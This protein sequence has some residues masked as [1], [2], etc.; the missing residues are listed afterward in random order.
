MNLCQEYHYSI[1]QVSKFYKSWSGYKDELC[2][3]VTWLYRAT[4]LDLFRKL[5][6]SGYQI[7]VIEKGLQIDAP[8]WNYQPIK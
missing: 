2:W 6:F 5:V 3:A 8:S 4:E 1:P 7:I